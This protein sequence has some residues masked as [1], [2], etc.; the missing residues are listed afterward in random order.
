MW[1]VKQSIHFRLAEDVLHIVDTMA[2]EWRVGRTPALERIC[3]EYAR[4]GGMEDSPPVPGQAEG[5][6]T[7]AVAETGRPGSNPGP[8]T[9]DV[10][11]CP[12]C[13][14]IIESWRKPIRKRKDAK[15]K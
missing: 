10:K 3:R 4:D 7:G 8:A 2:T 9:N 15:K 5:A 14:T 12:A 13:K 6:S 1:H 11:N